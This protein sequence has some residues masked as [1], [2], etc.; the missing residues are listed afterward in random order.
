MICDIS[1]STEF[2]PCLWSSIFAYGVL[3][4][5]VEFYLCLL[6]SIFVYGVLSLSME[7]HVVY[8]VLSLGTVLCLPG[9]QASAGLGNGPLLAWGN[10]CKRGIGKIRFFL[11]N[12]LLVLATGSCY[13][14]VE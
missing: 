3:S 7:S 4:L 10:I 6:I 5:H 1:L 8:G 9:E 14:T 2:Y 13:S 11:L 12:C